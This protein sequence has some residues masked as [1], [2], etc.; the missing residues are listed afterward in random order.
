MTTFSN[1]RTAVF[2][3]GLG[4]VALQAANVALIASGRI[5][6]ASAASVVISAVWWTNAHHA[7]VDGDPWLRWCYGAGAGVGTVIGIL[8]ARLLGG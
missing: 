3:R 4:Y 5:A 8:F 2:A 1:R 7:S 6:A